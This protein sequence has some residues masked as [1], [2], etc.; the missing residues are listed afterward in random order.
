MK[1]IHNESLFNIVKENAAFQ[2]REKA[3]KKA[4]MEAFYESAKV[5][6]DNGTENKNWEYKSMS[7]AYRMVMNKPLSDFY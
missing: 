7:K 4:A 5:K 3:A 1:I 6:N 2:K